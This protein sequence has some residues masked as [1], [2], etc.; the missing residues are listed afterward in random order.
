VTIIL[1]K[2][3]CSDA[4]GLSFAAYSADSQTAVMS[5]QEIHFDSESYI[6]RGSVNEP[7][8]RQSDRFPGHLRWIF[9]LVRAQELA[10]RVAVS[11]SRNSKKGSACRLRHPA[12]YIRV[13]CP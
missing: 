11:L 13:S 3:V 9:A 12:R 2:T 1:I 4:Y 8:P 5:V 6:A 7:E 10:G